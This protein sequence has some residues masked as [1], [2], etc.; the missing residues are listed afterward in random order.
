MPPHRLCTGTSIGVQDAQRGR[1]TL[2]EWP[3]RPIG[4]PGTDAWNLA[5]AVA[6]LGAAGRPGGGAAL[7]GPL[8][9]FIVVL[10]VSSAVDAVGGAVPP[11]RLAVCRVGAAAPGCFGSTGL[12]LVAVASLVELFPVVPDAPAAPAGARPGGARNQVPLT[13]WWW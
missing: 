13:R 8:G 6:F 10:A 7:V 12:L 3:A 1:V 4:A 5:L 11:Q 9:T 2:I